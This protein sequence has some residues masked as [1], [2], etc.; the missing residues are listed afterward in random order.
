[1][2]KLFNTISIELDEID[3][4]DLALKKESSD[5]F[6]KETI[7]KAMRLYGEFLRLEEGTKYITIDGWL[8][9]IHLE[10][11]ITEI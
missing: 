2:N 3:L 6:V 10:T 11:E 5:S 7:E 1:M 9:K 4:E 8:Y